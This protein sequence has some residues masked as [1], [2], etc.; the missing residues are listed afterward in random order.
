MTQE[1]L[2]ALGVGDGSAC[3]LQALDGGAPGAVAGGDFRR[4]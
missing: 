3:R 4:Q 2:F 1:I